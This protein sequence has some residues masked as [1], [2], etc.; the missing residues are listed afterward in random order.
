M[1][2]KTDKK[3]IRTL[4]IPLK[5]NDFVNE[6]IFQVVFKFNVTHLN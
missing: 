4:M 5:N 2:L 1:V 3:P 6:Q